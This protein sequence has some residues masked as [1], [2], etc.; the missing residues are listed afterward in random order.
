MS[1]YL[2]RLEE[3]RSAFKILTGNP[4]GKKPLGRPRNKW[5]VNVLMNLKEIGANARNRV[6][7][8]QADY[9]RILA[10]NFRVS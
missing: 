7:L 3:V 5:E 4:T 2:A 1:R 9:R 8:A 6:D 10:L